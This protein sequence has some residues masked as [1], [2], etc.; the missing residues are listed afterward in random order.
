MEIFDTFGLVELKKIFY[1]VQ[2]KYGV[3]EEINLYGLNKYDITS[4]LMNTKM[5]YRDSTTLVFNFGGEITKFTPNPRKCYYRG[6]KVYRTLVEKK[7]VTL[8]FS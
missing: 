4:L 7:N 6:P 8:D 3:F 5:F 2:K 1:V